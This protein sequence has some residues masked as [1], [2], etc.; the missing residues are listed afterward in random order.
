MSLDGLNTL[1]AIALHSTQDYCD[2][3]GTYHLGR[4]AEQSISDLH[5]GGVPQLEVMPLTQDS[6]GH[7]RK[8]R[9]PSRRD[10]HARPSR[11]NGKRGAGLQQARQPIGVVVASAVLRDHERNR[12]RRR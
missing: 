1:G 3:A 6:H 10:P 4:A 2:N 7:R 9:H 11:A 8:H 5:T 12:E